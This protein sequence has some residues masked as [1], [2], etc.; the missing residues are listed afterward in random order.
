MGIMEHQMET[1]IYYTR[2]HPGIME[3]K[4]GTGI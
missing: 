3:N 4:V 2:V 1:T